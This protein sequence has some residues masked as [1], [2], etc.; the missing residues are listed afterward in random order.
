MPYLNP[1]ASS[2][3]GNGPAASPTPKACLIL[4]R[5]GIPSSVWGEDAIDHLGGVPLMED[6]TLSLFLLV[7]DPETAAQVLGRAGYSR[8]KS[9]WSLER[10]P[11]YQTVLNTPTPEATEVAGAAARKVIL[12]AAD[13]F[14]HRLPTEPGGDV[15]PTCG[16]FLT[17]L[18]QTYFSLRGE[19]E[20]RLRLKLSVL[21]GRIYEYLSEAVEA[22]DFELQLPPRVR[23]LHRDHVTN[24]DHG[25][26]NMGDLGSWMCQKYYLRMME[27]DAHIFSPGG[28]E[29]A[30]SS[31]LSGSS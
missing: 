17:S 21:I 14:C 13:R 3:A 1:Q 6:S 5:A 30:S 16:K 12:L 15:Y 24:A 4:Q 28:G 10:I 2:Q 29:A 20:M 11:E 7:P 31:G 26:F 8:T 25:D 9:H 19:E 27:E 23:R 18:F 22:P